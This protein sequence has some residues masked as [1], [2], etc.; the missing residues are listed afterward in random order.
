MTLA[1]FVGTGNLREENI[2]ASAVSGFAVPR[3][4]FRLGERTF[5]TTVAAISGDRFGRLERNFD[6]KLLE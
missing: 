3:A 6:H 1:R 4:E 2:A 5:A